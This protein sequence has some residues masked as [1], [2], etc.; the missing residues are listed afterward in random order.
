MYRFFKCN[1]LGGFRLT[2]LNKKVHTDE[3]LYFEEHVCDT[4][5]SINGALKAKWM[6]EV[7]EKEASQS[8]SVPGEVKDVKSEPEQIET[9][10]KNLGKAQVDAK[11]TNK[12]LES[13]QAERNFR[14]PP[15]QKQKQEDK[16]AV[17]NFNQ[18]ER[19]IRERQ[20]DIMTK[21]SDE[22]LKSPMKKKRTC[23]YNKTA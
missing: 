20:A 21:G 19:R 16:P 10:K 9:T 11:E 17:P 4:S 1:R 2:D 8:I 12:S 23:S 22:L 3:Y 5:R 7:T 18:A 15:M 13:R 6:L 14:R